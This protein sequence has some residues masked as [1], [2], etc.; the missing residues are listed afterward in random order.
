M[1]ASMSPQNSICAP[2]VSEGGSEVVAPGTHGSGLLSQA[3]RKIFK[4]AVNMILC[5]IFDG[6]SGFAFYMSVW[7]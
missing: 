3:L 6:A 5:I 2:E 7:L 1:G 4:T